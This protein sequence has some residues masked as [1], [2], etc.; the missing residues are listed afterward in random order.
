MGGQLP[1]MVFSF[2]I[3][4]QIALSLLPHVSILHAVL[5]EKST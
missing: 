2:H 5:Q 3:T 1:G 4:L